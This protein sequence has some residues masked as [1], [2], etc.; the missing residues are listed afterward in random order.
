MGPA[1]FEVDGAS[2]APRPDVRHERAHANCAGCFHASERVTD[3]TFCAA[4]V[5]WTAWPSG[6]GEALEINWALPTGFRVRSP[7]RCIAIRLFKLHSSHVDAELDMVDPRN[8]V[9]VSTRHMHLGK[10]P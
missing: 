4:V 6:P 5:L 2:L 8:G 9:C 10:D 1:E 7:S 3:T